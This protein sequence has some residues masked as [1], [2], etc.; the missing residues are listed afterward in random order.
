MFT[1]I[2]V[3]THTHTHIYIY[4]YMYIY[5]YTHTCI[6]VICKL[7]KPKFQLR[8]HCTWSDRGTW[9]AFIV[10][11]PWS[12]GDIACIR[13]STLS[14]WTEALGSCSHIPEKRDRGFGV[15]PRGIALKRLKDILHPIPRTQIPRMS[16]RR[17]C[18]IC[19]RRKMQLHS[20]Q[21]PSC[22]ELRL[23]RWFRLRSVGF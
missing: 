1:Y 23:R 22:S 20:F 3:C 18:S 8:S 5:I 10:I 13:S 16:C 6:Y 9:V 2:R 12:I 14:S 11:M 7:R 17:S 4:I 19:Q 21:R 15:Y